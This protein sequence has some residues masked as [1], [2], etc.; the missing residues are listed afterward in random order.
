LAAF[1]VISLYAVP[2]TNKDYLPNSAF[3]NGQYLFISRKAYEEMGG[4][5]RVRDKFTEDLEIARY[6]K[7]AGKKI[8]I[9]YAH[10]FAQVRMYNSLSSI[11]RGW[12]RSFYAGS[13]GRPWRI[14]G[15]IGFILFS[16]YSAYIA[17]AWGI[18]RAAHPAASLPWWAW[19]ATASFHLILMHT[20]VA[21][22]YAWTCNRRR[23]TWIF[24][25]GA[26]LMIGIFLKALKMC[27]TKQ[28]EWRGTNYTHKMSATEPAKT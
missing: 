9:T 14:L 24:P 8:R 18:F 7:G 12:G 26:A 21:V 11:F 3:A 4:H 13:L 25:F 5:S 1:G 16:C 19:L 6:L 17:L 22:M 23:S 15:G 2:L 28:V 20:L 10:Q 27:A